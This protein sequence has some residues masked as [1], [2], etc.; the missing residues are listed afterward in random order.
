GDTLRLTLA[1]NH[2]RAHPT[3]S[4]T[5]AEM[6]LHQSLA[7]YRERFADAGDFTFY[8]VGNVDPAGLR[9]LVERWL[10]GLP[11]TGRQESGRDLGMRPPRGVV[12]KTVLRGL[13]PKARTQVVFTGPLEFSHERVGTLSA[14][15]E[16]L[17]IR[18]REVLRED[19]GGTYG[20]GVSASA[21][22]DP[23]P[24][25]TVGIGF[26]AAPER[27]RELNTAVLAQ[28]DSLKRTG[29]TAEELRKVKEARNRSY[30]TDLRDNSFWISQL[31]FYGN[32]GWDPREIL[33][34]P[35]R[36]E[37]LNAETI[38]D[39]ARSYLDTENLVQVTLLPEAGG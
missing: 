38:R 31:L 28:I 3:T 4:E 6:D 18:L 20:V 23:V 30:E 12:R 32:H 25:Y 22:R 16:V 33:R 7:F 36:T 37:A 35:E 26:G 11:S 24:G 1:Q 8:F 34:A 39:A 29:P 2:L 9:P 15:G 21:A 17:R 10:A 27:L 5:F 19:L 13:E 14:L